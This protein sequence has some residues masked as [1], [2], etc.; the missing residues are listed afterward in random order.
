MVLLLDDLHWADKPSLLLLEFVAREVSEARLLLVGT[1]RD[2]DVSRGDPLAQTLGELARQSASGGFER[3]LLRGMTEEDVSRFIEVETGLKAPAPLVSDVH[4][5]T[6][7]NPLFVTEVVRLL[8]QEGELTPERLREGKSLRQ[9]SGQ[10]WTVRIPEGVRE[11][12]GRRLDRLSELCNQTLTVA[13]VIGREFEMAQLDRLMDPSIDSGQTL[14]EDWLLDVLEEALSARIIE[15]LPAA[16][17]R[18]QFTHSLIQETLVEELSLTRQARL[19]ARIAEML[20]ELYGPEAEANAAELAHHFVQAE[21]VLGNERLVGYSL[22]AGELA[23]AGYGYEEAIV[24]FQRALTTKEG[25]ADTVHPEPVEGRAADSETAAALFGLGR[26]QTATTVEKAPAQQAWDHIQRAFEYYVASGDAAGAVAVAQHTLRTP[27]LIK[28]RVDVT[29]RALEFVPPDSLDAGRLLSQH[30]YSLSFEERDY[31]GAHQ[32]FDRAI[33]I[34]Q[35]LGDTALEAGTLSHSLLVDANNWRL[36]RVVESGPRAIELAQRANDLLAEFRA[37]RA[38][39]FAL[40]QKGDLDGA[41]QHATAS[42]EVAESLRHPDALASLPWLLGALSFHEG[43][44]QTAHRFYDRALEGIPDFPDGLVFKALAYYK[45]GDTEAGDTWLERLMTLARD[46]S[47]QLGESASMVL[48]WALPLVS[49]ITGRD[50]DLDLAERTAK[51]A[52]NT[53]DGMV[54]LALL[55]VH[56]SDAEAAAEQYQG[57]RSLPRFMELD[58]LLGLLAHTMGKFDD[59]SSH[60]EDLLDFSRKAGYRSD[61]AQ[62]CWGYADTLHERD[63]DGDREKATALLNESLSIARDLGMRPL[64]ERVAAR[65]EQ[66]QARAAAPSYPDGLTRREVEVLRHIIA[67]ATNQTIAGALFITTNTVANHVKNI[68]TKSNTENRT[69][70]AAYGVRHGLAEE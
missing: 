56:R 66:L 63:G 44:W 57:L 12:I 62:A 13:S 68:L 33:A 24:H 10:A 26:A 60:F 8:V 14:S 61:L 70:A 54:G 16:V 65:I 31:D 67:G 40:M 30:G 3:V 39:A 35:R 46:G 37:R 17:G 9:G 20:E 69:A 45:V 38:V 28:G 51:A 48:A 7:G 34:A 1:Y 2:V 52:P 55:A 36:D 58:H 11:V 49:L 64:E 25:R 42:L 27:H 43:D 22:I 18:Y 53:F 5:R 6:E 59:A 15:E 29:A 19:H 23:L 41:R 4:T 50:R 47:G 21:P 32:A